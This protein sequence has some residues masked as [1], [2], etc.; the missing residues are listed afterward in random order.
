MNSEIE[1]LVGSLC[2][3]SG[4][5][6]LAERDFDFV[7]SLIN[8]MHRHEENGC[9]VTTCGQFLSAFCELHDETVADRIQSN[10][11]YG[12]GF[13]A[14]FVS[15]LFCSEH[16]F[17][18][19]C[20]RQDPRDVSPLLRNTFVR[21]I[22]VLEEWARTD[23]IQIANSLC[24]LSLEI[25][26]GISNAENE[27]KESLREKS[28]NDI[29]GRLQRDSWPDLVNDL[30][31][32]IYRFGLPPF[33]DATAFKIKQGSP[34]FIEAI[35]SFDSFDLN[36]LEF[37]GDR[38]ETIIENTERF[39]LGLPAHNVL[40]WGPRG[41]GKSSLIRGLLTKYHSRKL[42]AIE[43]TSADYADFSRIY[44]SIRETGHRFIAVLDNVSFN[45]GDKMI[46]DLSRNMEGGLEKPPENL[47]FYA[48]SNYKDLVDREGDLGQGLGIMQMEE[49]TNARIA[50]SVRPEIYDPQQNQRIDELRA[51]DD[52]FALKVFIDLP[53]KSMYESMLGT[54]AER[55]GLVFN[56]RLVNEFNKWRMR[57]NHDLIGGRTVRD[58]I[59]YYA[60]I[61]SSLKM[62]D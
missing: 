27:I 57:H 50:N 1:S 60:G 61:Q 31:D 9:S 10:E 37:N 30:G 62:E 24:P 32:Y 33:R 49:D 7:K 46:R 39:V 29:I 35:N 15:K 11:S 52:R 56:E 6:L 59:Y 14:W 4:T 25:T 8:A 42:R 16:P 34:P 45:R 53:T 43:I 48:T 22:V 13:H 54:Y 44:S 28:L 58:F 18:I 19:E 17:L 51:L 36:W 5:G 41:G 40:V 21:Q 47:L 55:F 2:F 20:Q 23:W 26:N 3:A 38:F 12:R